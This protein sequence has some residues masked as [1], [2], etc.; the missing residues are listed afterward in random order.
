MTFIIFSVALAVMRNLYRAHVG[1]KNI[2]KEI[3]KRFR[4]VFGDDNGNIDNSALVNNDPEN[5]Y[6]GPGEEAKVPASDER[7]PKGSVKD[8]FKQGVGKVM[9]KF[10]K[11]DGYEEM[12]GSNDKADKEQTHGEHTRVWGP[13]G[14]ETQ[15][16]SSSQNV[17][18]SSG[19]S[20]MHTLF[21]GK[22][23]LEKPAGPQ[24]DQETVKA[25]VEELDDIMISNEEQ[26]T[27]YMKL[28]EY[29]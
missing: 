14:P 4:K 11:K 25:I 27:G 5:R 22:V 2:K 8:Y 12:S 26:P 28:D 15:I 16:D 17:G 1:K 29:L 3:K 6:T 21:G 24:T 18:P 9:G 19:S 10:G 13:N 23:N 20:I 7:D